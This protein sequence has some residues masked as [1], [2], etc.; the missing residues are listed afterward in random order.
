LNCFALNA[1]ILVSFVHGGKITHAYFRAP[2]VRSGSARLVGDLAYESTQVQLDVAALLEAL[3]ERLLDDEGRRH[4][5]RVDGADLGVRLRREEREDVVGGLAFR[6]LPD[7]CLVGPDA[8]EA[9]ERAALIER[10]PDVAAL[11]LV[12]IRSTS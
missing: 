11:G 7:G 12:E 1:R 10:E 2:Q 9:G 8:S 4:R 5:L 6:D 3:L